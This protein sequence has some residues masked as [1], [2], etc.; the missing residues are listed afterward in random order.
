MTKQKRKKTH[1]LRTS[2]KWSATASVQRCSSINRQD[3]RT[4]RLVYDQRL[5]IIRCAQRCLQGNTYVYYGP[6][7]DILVLEVYHSAGF[8]LCPISVQYYTAI[9][10]ALFDFTVSKYNAQHWRK[11][12]GC[13]RCKY[14]NRMRSVGVADPEKNYPNSRFN[15][16]L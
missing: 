5:L 8:I 10:S 16:F 11:F 12:P 14:T 9:C 7:S 13:S 4:Q 6:I 1:S 2:R 15:T 3:R